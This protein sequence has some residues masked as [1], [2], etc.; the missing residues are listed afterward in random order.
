MAKR[1]N[2]WFKI[3]ERESLNSE[4]ESR[5]GECEW[6]DPAYDQCPFYG[7]VRVEDMACKSFQEAE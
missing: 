7:E 5:C 4:Y 6:F 1:K 2:E 3:Q